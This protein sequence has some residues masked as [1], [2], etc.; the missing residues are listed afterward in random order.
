MCL[1]SVKDAGLPALKPEGLFTGRGEAA[2]SAT[3]QKASWGGTGTAAPLRLSTSES[4]NASCHIYCKQ[5][6]S[7]PF[8]Y[9]CILSSCL[10]MHF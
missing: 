4:R 10:G 2:A 5:I 1:V 8:A 9:P 6:W 7:L 3:V